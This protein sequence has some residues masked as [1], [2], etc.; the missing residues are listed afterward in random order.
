MRTTAVIPQAATVS[1]VVLHLRGVAPGE[2]SFSRASNISPASRKRAVRSRWHARSTKR[3]TEAEDQLRRYTACIWPQEAPDKRTRFA[4]LATDGKRF[5]AFAPVALRPDTPM[6][7]PG[8]VRL[9]LLEDVDVG[10]LSWSEFYYFLDRYLLRKSKLTPTSEY[11]VKDFGPSSRVFNL[12][13]DSLLRCWEGLKDNPEYAVRYDTWEKYLRIVYGSSLADHQLFVRHTYLATLAKL[14]VWRRLTPPEQAAD[15]P[16]IQAILEGSYFRQRLS[17]ENFL[18]EDFFSWIARPEA[19]PVGCAV[20]RDLLSLLA[21]Y[22]LNELSE[23]VLKSLYE[24]LVDPATRHDM[25]EYYTPDWLADRIV[26]KALQPNPEASVLDPA[27]GS[28]T[29][30]YMTIREKRRLLGD[31]VATL[32]HIVGAVV[33]LDIHPLAVIVAKANYVLALGGLMTR[34]KRKVSIPVYMAN[35]IS[36]PVYEVQRE[37]WHEV[38]CYRAEIAD[39]T[40]HIPQQ[41][42]HDPAKCDEAIE[43]AHDFAR[44][45]PGPRVEEAAFHNYLESRHPG[46]AEDGASARVLFSVAQTL[47][48]LIRQKRDSIWVYVLKNI[49]RPLFLEERFD[50]LLGNSPWLA[51]NRVERSDYQVFLK[52]LIRVEYGLVREQ[53]ENMPN[54]ELGTLFLVRAADLYLR[55]AGTVA[56]VLPKSVFSADQHDGLRRHT[57]SRPALQ[58]VEL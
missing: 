6:C 13:E 46:L 45:N 34:R 41:L 32:Q 51:Y 40:V 42:I 5:V 10:K 15:A 29:F 26:R 39:T 33:G 50:L 37:L 49:Y 53:I 56:F 31:S 55:E 35:S 24:G 38:P 54:M 1:A 3:L 4:C 28:G 36:P 8:D 17:M 22:N 43:V 57:F 25:G 48:G 58:I 18:E 19:G 52:R 11:I 20:A 16:T 7:E 44:T 2:R 30:L 12:S 23:D 27:C 21:D 47:H 9:G 14:M